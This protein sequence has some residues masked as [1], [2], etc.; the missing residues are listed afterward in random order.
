[1]DIG[2][3]TR[4]V[5]TM[6]AGGTNV[7]FSAM[8]KGRA[9]VEPLCLPSHGDDLEKCLRRIVEGFTHIQKRLSGPAAAISF[10]FPGPADYRSGIIG[11]L[12]NMPAFRGGVPLGPILEEHF[13]VP[14]LINNDGD[15][16][17]YG[18]AISG[19]LPK[20]NAA[21]KA[22]GSSRRF[23][24]L[25]GVTI[26][27]GFGAG[28]VSGE[29]LYLGDN[30]AGMEIW[31]TR[32]NSY[33]GCIAEEGVCAR[34][35]RRVYAQE[36]GIP[37]SETPEPRQISAI[38]E[39][40]LPGNHVAA[41]RAFAALGQALGECLADA[42]CMTDSLVVV[43][44]GVSLAHSHFLD[45]AVARMNGKL[46]TV[47]G[48]ALRRMEVKA[49]NLENSEQ[50]SAFLDESPQMLRVAGTDRTVPFFVDKSIGV[51]VSVLGTNEA[52]ALGAYA[53]AL[54]ALDGQAQD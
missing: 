34:A 41:S 37:M 11:D 19:L 6:D 46:R 9:L 1:M 22:S 28:L 27:T 30:G 47:A 20:T 52:V 50:R 43:G 18:E 2:T 25:L 42:V 48:R 36:A 39:G 38:S 16:F 12:P 45:T 33:E 3:D 32:S 23:N 5:L 40:A 4:T 44:G 21:L 49:Y 24:N 29:R 51:G 53:F 8:A 14:V 17:V 13:G 54:Q 26:G 7:A 15:L 35:L 10:G 31:S